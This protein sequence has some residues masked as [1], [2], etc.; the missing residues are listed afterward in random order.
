MPDP[1]PCCVLVPRPAEALVRYG[2]EELLRGLGRQPVWVRAPDA[3][4]VAG[5]GA[6]VEF[7]RVPLAVSAAAI[8]GLLAPA[9]PH[10]PATV[11]IEG[12]C[13]PLPVGT[14]A[15]GDV[16]ASAAW[17]LAGLQER[18]VVAR[19][20]HGRVPFEATLT[21]RLGDAPGGPLQP[22]VDAYRRWLAGRL[23]AAG[24]S[25]ERRRWRGAPWA[26]ALTHD[27]DAVREQRV[28]G[29]VGEVARGRPLQGL[30]RAL[31]PDRRRRSLAAL[32]ALSDR[33]GVRATWFVKPGAW[34]PEDVRQRLD[35][36]AVR[37]LRQLAA[38]GH[39]I[40]W[41]PGH[42][43]HDH[44]DRLATE[45]QRFEGAFGHAPRVARTHF[46]RWAEPATPRLLA[47]NGVRVDS[48]LGFSEHEGFRRGTSHP[49]RLFDHAADA[50][51]PLWEVPLA[52]MDTT[53]HVHRGL[54]AD[55]QAA[56]L[57]R[58][59]D[60]A[61]HAG[62][63]AVVLWHNDLGEGAPW[64]RRLRVLDHA[65]GQ[66]RRDGATVGPVGAFATG[67]FGP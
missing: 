4:V 64:S 10:A 61:R 55:G 7:A 5:P 35:A 21:A 41:H 45:R 24:V 51:T 60:A 65:L 52:V 25:T 15:P 22:P 16:V 28:R 6:E 58:V 43:A 13:W 54:D 53:L 50:P 30:W 56:A 18:A 62:G 17:W 44:P 19:D 2:L 8:D 39:E 27:L 57:A 47:Q 31:A 48:S 33:H 29:L 42:G 32:A 59:F 66:A 14:G 34:A 40:A 11:D 37:R 38:D 46:L 49:F 36:E 26:V 9:L 23:A 20:E 1:I 63:C 67:A 12:T 3:T